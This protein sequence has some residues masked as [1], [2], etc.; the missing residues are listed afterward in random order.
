MNHDEDAITNNQFFDK[1]GSKKNP[2]GRQC[3]KNLRG[4]NG[5]HYFK[6]TWLYVPTGRLRK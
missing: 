6:Q 1:G 3:I 4:K 5:V 2:L